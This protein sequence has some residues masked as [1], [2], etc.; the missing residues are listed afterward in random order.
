MGSQLSFKLLHASGLTRQNQRIELY[1]ELM[2]DQSIVLL[3]LIGRDGDFVRQRYCHR[4][5]INYQYANWLCKKLTEDLIQLGFSPA[6]GP[7]IWSL[8][9]MQEF[10][11]H[12]LFTQQQDIDTEF[13]PLGI[14]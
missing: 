8:V 6:S 2:P 5:L 14:I 13:V 4:D 9:A 12:R 1:L 11:A 7:N 3:M 10:R